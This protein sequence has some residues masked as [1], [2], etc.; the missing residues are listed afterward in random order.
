MDID[1]WQEKQAEVRGVAIQDQPVSY[2]E[3]L[4]EQE[5]VPCYLW[6]EIMTLF[7]IFLEKF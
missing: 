2:V 6:K 1:F 5:F 4:A 7:L 3:V